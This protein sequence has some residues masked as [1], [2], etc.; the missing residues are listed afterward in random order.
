MLPLGFQ[1]TTNSHHKVLDHYSLSLWH[2][3][4][5]PLGFGL[6]VREICLLP[7]NREREKHERDSGD[8]L[9]AVKMA[10][11]VADMCVWRRQT[12]RWSWLG[13]SR[14]EMFGPRTPVETKER[15][16]RRWCSGHPSAREGGAKT[17]TW[18]GEAVAG[19]VLDNGEKRDDAS[20]SSA[21]GGHGGRCRVEER[22]EQESEGKW[23][24]RKWALARWGALHFSLAS[25]RGADEACMRGERSA[26]LGATSTRPHGYHMANTIYS[27]GRREWDKMESSNHRPLQPFCSPLYWLQLCYRD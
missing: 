4:Q 18:D 14:M 22:R 12:R 5:K 6:I 8:G 17:G 2:F 7:Q 3:T 24:W 16:R 25:R 15:R 26:R 20:T 13:D 9:P 11:R 1:L 19:L 10:R 27:V 23:V 21:R